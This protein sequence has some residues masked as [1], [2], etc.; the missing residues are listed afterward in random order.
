MKKIISLIIYSSICSLLFSSF[1]YC[2]SGQNYCERCEYKNI[3][4]VPVKEKKN[5]SAPSD[6][7]FSSNSSYSYTQPL[8]KENEELAE[9]W[10][11]EFQWRDDTDGGLYFRSLTS[12]DD[13][14]LAASIESESSG[15]YKKY[16]LVQALA[17]K[18]MLNQDW[19][20][21]KSIYKKYKSSFPNKEKDIEELI[22]ILSEK[23]KADIRAI[24]EVNSQADE[25][26][27]IPEASNKR[28][29]FSS[30]ER[31]GGVG[32]EDVF[33]SDYNPSERTWSTPASVNGISTGTHEAPLD[34]SSDG[35][36]IFLF[37]NYGG[38]PGRGDIFRSQD[39]W[40]PF[41]WKKPQALPFPVNT[42]CFESDFN[43][44]ADKKKI[45]FVSDR[46]DNLYPYIRKSILHSGHTWGN[47]DIFI[48]D[49][50]ED[51][52]FSNV[53]NIGPLLNTPGAERS[54]YL[55]PDG[56]TLYFSSNGL[57]GFGDLDIFKT[58]R[59]DD[60]WE[61]WSKPVNLG[62]LLNSS[63]SNWGF[64]LTAAGD[65]GFFSSQLNNATSED[66]YEILP[67]PPRA[68]PVGGALV[69]LGKVVDLAGKPMEAKI[70]WTDFRTGKVIGILSN[71]PGTGEFSA[72]LPTG[73]IFSYIIQTKEFTTQPAKLDMSKYKSY[74]EIRVNIPPVPIIS[75]ESDSFKTA[76]SMNTGSGGLQELSSYS[77]NFK[78]GR[79]V[80]LKDSY[81]EMDKI[82]Q[83]LNREQNPP[84]FIQGHTATGGTEKFN[85]LLSKMRA[86]SVADYLVSKGFP[87]SNLEVQGLG[88]SK[89]IAPNTDEAGR[90]KNR[91]VSIV[92]K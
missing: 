54:P 62:K 31:S 19:E 12:K 67:L 25:Y 58:V 65:R 66:I 24:N 2:G 55:H 89:P 8:N 69:I 49:M 13:A 41:G 57:N 30:Y 7:C 39:S 34:I 74:S 70:V 35:V 73:G 51:G 61:K 42:N 68:K 20:G 72:I 3:N 91:R 85:L 48:A 45:L 82:L 84:I 10:K 23:D 17:G 92:P 40:K 90:K 78:G 5:N 44:T 14:F 87:K 38:G 15:S 63:S 29:Y 46:P 75:K 9:K 86:K 79:D 26:T 28:I 76:R 56:K 16:M 4:Y 59:L 33:V 36:E 83:V 50:D 32:G 64:R 53:K 81:P 52:N 27:P 60:S 43:V 37:G 6:S 22:K 88:S 71:K 11:K 21:A 80:I 1:W 18:K 77:I 47:T